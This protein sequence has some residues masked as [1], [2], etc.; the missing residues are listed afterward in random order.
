MGERVD[1]LHLNEGVL[2]TL[3]EGSGHYIPDL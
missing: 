1:V 3:I 2:N